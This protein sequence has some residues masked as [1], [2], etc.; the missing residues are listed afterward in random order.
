MTVYFLLFLEGVFAFV[1]PCILPLLPVYLL[2]LAGDKTKGTKQLIINTCG[3]IFGFSFIFMALGATATGFGRLLQENRN[4]LLTGSGIFI[5]LLGIYYLLNG[6]GKLDIQ[7]HWQQLKA[8]FS[9]R[10]TELSN[11]DKKTESLQ[12]NKPKELHFFSSFGF[13]IAFCAGWTPCIFTWL[14]AALTLSANSETVYEGIFMLGIFSLGLGLPFLL[15][16]LFFNRLKNTLSLL[17]RQLPRI[18]K[19]SGILL[20]ILGIAMLTGWFGRYLAI[21]V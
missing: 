18:Q 16:A 4:A 17:R 15:F 13:G 20:I 10:H 5:L 9:K 21:F 12:A 7:Q 14:A 6:M 19:I 11:S 1:S 2:Y 3:F 8:C